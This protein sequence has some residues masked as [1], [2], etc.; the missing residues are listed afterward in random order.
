MKK[1]I[2][3]LY[4]VLACFI[5]AI[6]TIGSTYAYWV[7]TATST[8]NSVQTTSATFKINMEIKPLYAGFS[9]IPMNDTDALK[10][11]KNKCKDKY[12]RGACSSY[13]IRVFGYHKELS[14]I[15]GYLDIE[16]DNMEN[17][18]YMVLEETEEYNEENC[19]TIE[20][21]NYCI[22]K[23][24]TPMGEGKE[25]SIGESYSVVG[26]EE[27]YLILVMWL[28]N[29]N[30]DQNKNDIGSYNTTVTI[31]AGNGGEIRGTIANSV[32][33]EDES[34]PPEEPTP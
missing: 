13:V 11:L 7:S 21:K 31:L 9:Y 1:K 15:S 16:T 33:I 2:K 18:S 3:A 25:L 12:N 5:L 28:S 10:A 27:K 17:I 32:I 19:I 29:L 30:K 14:H 24:A 34:E 20:E 6:T 22:G 23:T 8:S 26:L 4:A